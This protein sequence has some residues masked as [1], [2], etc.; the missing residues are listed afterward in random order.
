MRASDSITLLSAVTTGT[1][2]AIPFQQFRTLGGSVV[3]SGTVSGGAV[4]FESAPTK[5]YA[6]T[7][8]EVFSI[9]P[10]S[11]ANVT[12][13]AA[14]AANFVRARVTSNIT[15]GATITVYANRSTQPLA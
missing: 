15:G 2:S 4:I 12:D 1:S 5:D 3:A 10:A 13:A 11:D 6:G 14:V 9:T 8:S 7:W